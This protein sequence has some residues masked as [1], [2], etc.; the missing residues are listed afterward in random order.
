MVADQGIAKVEQ[1]RVLHTK[2]PLLLNE[3]GVTAP[4]VARSLALYKS[5]ENTPIWTEASEAEWSLERRVI[6]GREFCYREIRN[7]HLSA[8]F[9]ID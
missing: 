1:N 4:S 5:R 7:K 2:K 6:P 3:T 8:P 9:V